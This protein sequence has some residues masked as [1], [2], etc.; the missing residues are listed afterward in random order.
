MK[1]NKGNIERK[2][3]VQG[4][5][6]NKGKMAARHKRKLSAISEG[7]CKNEPFRMER[8]EDE[9]KDMRKKSSWHVLCT[10]TYASTFGLYYLS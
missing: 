2:V 7:G 1:T 5:R 9:Q 10:V 6:G 3:G 4:S 8:L